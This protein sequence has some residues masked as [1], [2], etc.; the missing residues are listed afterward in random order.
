MGLSCVVSFGTKVCVR[1]VLQNS[2]TQQ[3]HTRTDLPLNVSRLDGGGTGLNPFLLSIQ[4]IPRTREG[5]DK[6]FK[7][8]MLKLKSKQCVHSTQRPQN[9]WQ[10]PDP[11]ECCQ[12]RYLYQPLQ[13]LQGA[14]RSPMKQVAGVM[15]VANTCQ[16]PPSH[17]SG[18]TPSTLPR[19]S[20]CT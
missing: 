18:H 4:S 16:A 14:Q 7:R 17:M 11:P 2:N 6:E 19:T 12:P 3:G 5:L 15:A 8:C 20:A 10:S 1:P 9:R 13:E